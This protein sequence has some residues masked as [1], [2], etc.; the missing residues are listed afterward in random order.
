MPWLILI[1]GLVAASTFIDAP[2]PAEL[3]LQHAPTPVA[4]AV[5]LYLN[6]RRTLQRSSILCLLGFLWLHILGARWLYT[7]VPYDAWVRAVCGSSPSDWFG[8]QRNH[9]D[10]LVHFASGCLFLPPIVD[11]LR[12]RLGN[13]QGVAIIHSIAWIMAIG[14]IYEIFEWQLAVRLAPH[15]AESYNGQ[16]GDVWDPQKDLLAAQLGAIG[17]TSGMMFYKVARNWTSTW[18]IAGHT[19]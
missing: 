15:M 5:L 19:K 14:S 4:L 10:R 3:R 11:L 12:N 1:T 7:M 2:Y 18:R 16:Q 9:Y 6:H 8:W 17:I 13:S